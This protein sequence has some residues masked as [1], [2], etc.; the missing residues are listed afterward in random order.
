MLSQFPTGDYTN[1]YPEEELSDD[2]EDEDDEMVEKAMKRARA[3]AGRA[4][5]K[6]ARH[7]G[8][9]EVR[10]EDDDD[11]EDLAD[12]IADD[13][14]EEEEDDDDDADEFGDVAIKLPAEVKSLTVGQLR[15]LVH[16]AGSK[17]DINCNS[18]PQLL[19][20]LKNLE[21]DHVLGTPP[22]QPRRQRGVR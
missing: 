5:K 19:A 21:R 17:S 12:F 15:Q 20:K 3:K 2:D 22:R 4:G 13:D 14:E 18:K 16:L 8:D 6:A 10:S 1:Q 11:D 7:F 9:D